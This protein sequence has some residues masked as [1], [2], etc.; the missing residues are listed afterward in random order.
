MCTVCGHGVFK[1]ESDGK[2]YK[3]VKIGEQIIMSENYAKKPTSG[4]F[5]MYDNNEDNVVKYGYLYDWQTA[6]TIAPKGWH[7]PSKAEWKTVFQSLGGHTPEVFEQ[8][9]AGGS[10]GFEALFGGWRYVRGSFT[11]LGG[12]AHFWSETQENETH[13]WH[14]KIGVSGHH[15]EPEKGEKGLGLS[16]RLFKDK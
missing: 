3:L 16:I 2:M 1:D 4:N 9:K 14:F 15:A 5:W 7:L 10:S 13:A 6:K 12:S 11:G 8:L